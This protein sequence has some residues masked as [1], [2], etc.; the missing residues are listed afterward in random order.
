M[1][2]LANP[3]KVY[4]QLMDLLVRLARHGLIHGDFNEFNLMIKEDESLHSSVAVL[5]FEYYK[6]EDELEVKLNNLKSELQCIVSLNGD[7]QKKYL[8]FGETQSPTLFDF[9]DNVN[10]IEFLNGL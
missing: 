5:Y 2:E 8:K 1:S 3:H 9:A 4:S 6:N 7:I 10:T